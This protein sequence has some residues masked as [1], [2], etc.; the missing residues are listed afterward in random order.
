MNVPLRRAAVLGHPV[1]HSLSPVLHTAAYRALG[2]DGWEYG[3]HDVTEDTLPGF[4]RGLGPEWAGLSLTMPLKHAII[5]LLDHVEPLAEAVGAVNTVLFSTVRGS[6]TTT[7]TNTDVHGIVAALREGLG[8]RRVTDA[9]IL[10]GGATA[11]SALAAVA[12]LGCASPRVFVRSLDRIGPLREAVARMGVS[13]SFEVF[14]EHATTSALATADAVVSTTPKYAADAWAP[15]LTD[16][17]TG[18]GEKPRGVLLDVVYD[19]RPTALQAA[20]ATL[21]ADAVGGERMLLHQAAEQVR[22]MTGRPA[23][24]AAMDE[25]L[26]S[27]LG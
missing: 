9:A 27:A 3:V 17:S 10:G 21:G 12:E 23:P 16:L 6:V 4:L 22:L 1:A 13:P 18:T 8:A 19:P 25:A 7:G 24:L 5:G 11:A 14:D 20:W 2:L 26:R 15:L